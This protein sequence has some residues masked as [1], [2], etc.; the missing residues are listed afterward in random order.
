M[1]FVISGVCKI[2]NGCVLCIWC[3]CYPDRPIIWEV[4]RSRLNS[5]NLSSLLIGDFNQIEY[6]LDKL[7]GSEKIRGWEEFMK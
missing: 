6:Y 3:T 1:C 4:I 2:I 5:F 7:G